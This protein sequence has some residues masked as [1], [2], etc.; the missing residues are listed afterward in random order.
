MSIHPR[1]NL[2]LNAVFRPHILY[3]KPLSEQFGIPKPDQ[4][5][6]KKEKN[7]AVIGIAAISLFLS[8][9][10]VNAKNT[11]NSLPDYAMYKKDQKLCYIDFSENNSRQVSTGLF[12][13]LDYDYSYFSEERV[14]NKYTLSQ[15]GRLLFFPDA[16][17][18]PFFS[19]SCRN[20]NDPK[21]KAIK[22]DSDI[23]SYLVNEDASIITYE[24]NNTLFRYN[25]KGRKR[26]TIANNIG[27]Y[28]ASPDGNTILYTS[29]N[30]VFYYTPS[31]GRREK[32][33]IHF[34]DINCISKDLS[35]IYY[36]SS[37]GHYSLNKKERGKENVKIDSEVWMVIK[38][39]PSGKLYYV[40]VN[41]V[42]FPLLHYVY[43]DKKEFDAALTKPV[44]PSRNSPDYDTA[45]KA[46]KRASKEYLAKLKRDEIRKYLEEAK[47]I[48][49]G[50]SHYAL[51]Y[52]DGE[53]STLISNSFTDSSFAFAADEPIITYTEYSLLDDAGVNLSEI[54][55]ADKVVRTVC[56][57]LCSVDR[58]V[59]FGASSVPLEWAEEEE[60][61]FCLSADGK[62]LY[63]LV[64]TPK[65][66]N[67]GDLYQMNISS[68][69]KFGT[70]KL[71]DRN[72]FCDNL[73]SVG[74]NNLLYLKNYKND[75]GELYFNREKMDD[76]VT[77]II[78]VDPFSTPFLQR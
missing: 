4:K 37:D 29:G 49:W 67:H 31:N 71:Y 47:R 19:L 11:D 41:S 34:Y 32:V 46:Y 75:K 53:K 70:P 64:K 16:L 62:T 23:R 33:D 45:Y 61:D 50:F 56:D 30:E 44:A 58:Y 12:D 20:V 2:L 66:E 78:P 21:A 76:N 17:D 28:Y 10:T 6:L 65:N 5:S 7:F 18:Y 42:D 9:F 72:V 35:T 60:T 22:I 36:I 63:Y 73:Y 55:D 39:Y 8:V 57:S 59:A 1:C 27:Y 48:R 51:Y 54:E 3:Q 13:I 40:T 74:G 68:L 69:Q 43:D 24:K 26:Q 52:Y 77:C 15:D 14:I 38:A 25:R